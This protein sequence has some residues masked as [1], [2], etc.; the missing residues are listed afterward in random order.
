MSTYLSQS[1]N[2]YTVIPS[3]TGGEGEE[4]GLSHRAAKQV[5]FDK[6]R[7]GFRSQ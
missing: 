7:A 2:E 5:A 4:S 1:G 3:L 6:L